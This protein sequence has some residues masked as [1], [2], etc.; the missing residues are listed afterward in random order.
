MAKLGPNGPKGQFAEYRNKR[1]IQLG[2]KIRSMLLKP[3][4]ENRAMETIK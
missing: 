1:R 2:I 3:S 4:V